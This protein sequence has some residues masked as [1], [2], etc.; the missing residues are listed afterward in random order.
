K[1]SKE[2]SQRNATQAEKDLEEIKKLIEESGGKLST[3]SLQ[4]ELDFGRRKSDGTT[5]LGIVNPAD[6]SAGGNTV[7][8]PFHPS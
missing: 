5:T 8:A 3:R 1:E 7:G 4:C 6:L 2:E